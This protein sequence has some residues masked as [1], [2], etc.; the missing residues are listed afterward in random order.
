M[1]FL[2]RS[3]FGAR[4]PVLAG[5]E[6]KPGSF[7]GPAPGVL[8]VPQVTAGPLPP[9]P[10]SA[11][12]TSSTPVPYQSEMSMTVQIRSKATTSE[13]NASSMSAV[14]DGLVLATASSTSSSVTVS[15]FPR[16]LPRANAVAAAR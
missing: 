6:A 5:P 9:N 16:S 12:S 10:A 3:R 2:P 14:I 15:A 4:S 8:R 7:E 1:T 13:L 11:S